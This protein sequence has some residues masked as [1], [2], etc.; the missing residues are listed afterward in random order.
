M[1][2]LATR[3]ADTEY[4]PYYSRYISKVPEGDVVELLRAQ[5]GE[6]LALLHGLPEARAEHR[7]ADGKWSIKEVV[8]HVSDAERIFSY[9]ALRFARGDDTALAS[10]DE[11]AFVRRASFGRRTLTSLASE[12][13]AVRHATIALYDTMTEA[14]AVRVGIAS[15]VQ[16][17]PRALAYIIAGH[18]RH[19][20]A[21]LRERYL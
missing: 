19:H 6:T 13:E 21:I 18:E 3:P 15:E 11:N 7:Y 8:G 2:V 17:T 10:F 20:V 12:F 4:A 16:V 14:E 5:L 9:R 1:S